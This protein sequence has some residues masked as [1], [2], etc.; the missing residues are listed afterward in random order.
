[1]IVHRR[2][3]RVRGILPRIAD[4]AMGIGWLG[5]RFMHENTLVQTA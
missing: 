2:R 5:Y 4:F 1:M 3:A